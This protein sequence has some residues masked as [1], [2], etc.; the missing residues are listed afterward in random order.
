[1]KL[2]LFV[3]V[4]STANLWC[5]KQKLIKKIVEQSRKKRKI[6]F[7]FRHDKFSKLS[8]R[9]SL[10]KIAHLFQFDRYYSAHAHFVTRGPARWRGHGLKMPLRSARGKKGRE[11]RQSLTFINFLSGFPTIPCI[12]T[13]IVLSIM[14]FFILLKKL[15]LFEIF[16]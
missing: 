7:S 2:Y 6:K 1:M 14:L 8:K 9:Y 13:Y 11:E 10:L 12:S 15:F 16:F 3:R 5:D 4:A